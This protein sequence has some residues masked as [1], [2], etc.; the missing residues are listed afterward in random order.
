MEKYLIEGL[1]ADLIIACMQEAVSRNKRN[2]HYV[3]S[4]LNDCCNNNIKT[5]QQFNI[6]QKEFK[7]NNNSTK[8]AKS[9]EKAEYDEVEFI[10]EEEYKK[11]ILGKG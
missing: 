2:W 10:N 8:K 3:V 4:I 6:K 5:A 1:Q 11:K 9:K 7:S